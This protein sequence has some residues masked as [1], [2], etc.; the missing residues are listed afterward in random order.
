MSPYRRLPSRDCRWFKQT[1]MLIALCLSLLHEAYALELEDDAEHERTQIVLRKV[2]NERWLNYSYFQILD[3]NLYQDPQIKFSD[4]IEPALGNCFLKAVNQYGA[5]HPGGAPSGSDPWSEIAAHCKKYSDD[6]S[7][8]PTYYK[9]L[10][11]RTPDEMLEQILLKDHEVTLNNPND[12]TAAEHYEFLKKFYRPI[13]IADKLYTLTSLDDIHRLAYSVT[14]EL[15]TQQ[16][17][18]VAQIFGANALANYDQD[19]TKSTSDHSSG[20][21]SLVDMLNAERKNREDLGGSLNEKNRNRAGVCRDIAS[22]QAE[23]LRMMGMKST[24]VLSYLTRATWHTMV[25]TRDPEK[26]RDIYKLNYDAFIMTNE[27][28][29]QEALYPGE[30]DASLDY[31]IAEPSGRLLKRVDSEL[32]KMLKEAVNMRELNPFE[33]STTNLAAVDIKLGD[34]T[35]GKVFYGS[36]SHGADYVGAG[37]NQRMV[38]NEHHRLELGLAYIGSEDRKID[39]L[40]AH[41]RHYYQREIGKWQQDFLTSQIYVTTDAVLALMLP[42]EHVTDPEDPSWY[43]R[44]AGSAETRTGTTLTIGEPEARVRG[45]IG[46]EVLWAIGYADVRNASISTVR[47]YPTD[48]IFSAEGR[49]RLSASPEGKAFLIA[50]TKVLFDYFGPKLLAELAYQDEN[51]RVAVQTIG[52]IEKEEAIWVPGAERRVQLEYR[53]LVSK[54]ITPLAHPV[55]LKFTVGVKEGDDVIAPK[56]IF[57]NGTLEVKF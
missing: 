32:G 1:L 19:R 20:T 49:L 42:R 9:S 57:A 23:L 37:F 53:H 39:Y 36:D 34:N 8:N 54:L 17:L 7:K 2:I 11:N 15:N 52:R 46:A 13:I 28:T 22:A 50:A 48:L 18:M 43:N 55:N 45:T 14:Q 29:A 16:K 26:P 3:G 30:R 12:K 25:L 44:I 33:R 4:S 35:W 47:I 38:N 51:S 41:L 31:W 56:L 27:G 40:Y 5:E 21:V 24:Y 6:F 10:R